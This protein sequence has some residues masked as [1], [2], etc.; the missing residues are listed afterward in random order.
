M[1][2]EPL[3]RS[4]TFR[5]GDAFPSSEALARWLTGCCMAMNDLVYLNQQLLPR[6]EGNAPAWENVYLARLVGS[7]LYEAAKFLIEAEKRYRGD[8]QTFIERLPEEV[9]RDYEDVKALGPGGQ[10]AL[11]KPLERLRNHF[12]HCAELIPQAPQYEELSGALD[13]HADKESTIRFGDRFGDFRADFAD[14]VAAE[15]TYQGDEGV[16]DFVGGLAQA[17]I[18][19]VRFAY[20]ALEQHLL[21]EGV[22]AA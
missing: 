14:D 20:A 3:T 21:D 2:D 19:Y 12:F 5:I 7:H 9:R 17:S 6:L 8:L 4:L 15:L 22:A 11:A 13:A 16:G 1:A 10:S 18:T